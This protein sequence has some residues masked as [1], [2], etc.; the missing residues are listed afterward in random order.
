MFL[1]NL[2]EYLID[3]GGFNFLALFFGGL[4]MVNQIFKLCKEYISY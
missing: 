4:F 1:R 3:I 2:L